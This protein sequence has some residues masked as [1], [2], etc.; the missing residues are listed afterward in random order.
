MSR[1][2]A[3]DT[4]FF[5]HQPSLNRLEV[6][7]NKV[8]SG[9][10]VLT[11]LQ[12]S[13]SNDKRTGADAV[14]RAAKDLAALLGNALEALGLD[15]SLYQPLFSLF[16]VERTLTGVAKGDDGGNLA[17]GSSRKGLGRVVDE[18]GSLGVAREN[19]LGVGALLVSLLNNR[20]PISKG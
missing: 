17:G 3:P 1:V 19:D 8:G 4:S 9:L 18:H 11:V 15:Y 13:S 16:W 10:S 5:V 2:P 7:S 14:A 20:H 6:T 12:V